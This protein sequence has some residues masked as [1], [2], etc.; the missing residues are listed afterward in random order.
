V[1]NVGWLGCTNQNDARSPTRAPRSQ[2]AVTESRLEVQGF[3]DAFPTK[4]DGS[5]SKDD[6]GEAYAPHK[7]EEP[8]PHPAGAVT[9]RS[10]V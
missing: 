4:E 8:A 6:S 10:V 7:E 5:R 2:F 1:L 9:C 3:P